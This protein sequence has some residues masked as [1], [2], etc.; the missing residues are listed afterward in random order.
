MP[1]DNHILTPPDVGLQDPGGDPDESSR[2]QAAYLGNG[3]G[4]LGI[5]VLSLYLLLVAA[6]SIHALFAIWPNPPGGMVAKLFGSRLI[7][8]FTGRDEL[9]LLLIAL[10]AGTLGS[11]VQV[12]SSFVTF[13]GN[14]TFCRSWALWY[15][16][17]PVIGMTLATI[18]YCVIRG[19]LLPMQ[20]DAAVLSP[21]GVAAA[22]GLVGLF[23][24]E[25]TDKLK[26]AFDVLF[27]PKGDL[28]R[29]DKLPDAAPK[30]PPAAALPAAPPAPPA[31]PPAPLHHFDPGA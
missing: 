10:L 18:S 22:A 2:F 30:A 31:V 24:K 19:G 23:S 15:Y 20:A 3:M 1:D 21:F 29:V 28:H 5:L 9:R 25:A 26:E 6:V 4:W 7:V 14:R 11:F 12:S 17:R 27:Q 13:L 16:F 8:D